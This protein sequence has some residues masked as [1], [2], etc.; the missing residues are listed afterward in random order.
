MANLQQLLTDYQTYQDTAKTHQTNWLSDYQLCQ[1]VVNSEKCVKN[2]QAWSELEAFKPTQGWI[3]LTSEV[4]VFK[5]NEEFKAISKSHNPLNGEMINASG[6]TSLHLR[7]HVSGD[8]QLIEMTQKQGNTH[9]VKTQ[10]IKLKSP[11][12][13]TGEATYSLYGQMIDAKF[14]IS[15]SR[16]DGFNKE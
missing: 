3:T 2:D 14:V 12:I 7:P 15:F 13:K 4:V 11:S 9:L 10:T 8:L 16:F 6:N 1:L 5:S